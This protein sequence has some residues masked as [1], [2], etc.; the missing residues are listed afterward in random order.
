MFEQQDDTFE[1]THDNKDKGN[2]QEEQD[3]DETAQIVDAPQ[4]YTSTDTEE[5]PSPPS[6]SSN[7]ATSTALIQTMSEG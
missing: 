4:E 6:T 1:T 7:N 2:Q 5:L 3:I